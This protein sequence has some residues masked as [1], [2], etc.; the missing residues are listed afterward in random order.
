MSG[1]SHS[2]RSSG[3]APWW[4]SPSSDIAYYKAKLAQARSLGQPTKKI[5]KQLELLRDAIVIY[6]EHRL[7]I[8]DSDATIIESEKDFARRFVKHKLTYVPQIP[9]SLLVQIFMSELR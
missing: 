2:L 5:E 1:E 4:Q 3:T 7:A 8:K 6:R 9:N